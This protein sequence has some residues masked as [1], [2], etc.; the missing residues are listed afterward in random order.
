MLSLENKFVI[1]LTLMLC[2]SN[3]LAVS[4]HQTTNIMLPQQNAA[5]DVGQIQPCMD[6]R[7]VSLNVALKPF[8]KISIAI[9]GNFTVQEE[10]EFT[11]TLFVDNKYKNIFKHIQI[12]EN[13]GSLMIR[14]G[15]RLEKGQTPSFIGVITMPG[16]I[17]LNELSLWDHGILKCL[18]DIDTDF[19]NVILIDHSS[20]LLKGRANMHKICIGRTSVYNAKGIIAKETKGTVFSNSYAI[21]GVPGKMDDLKKDSESVITVLSSKKE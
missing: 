20:A 5:K 18:N 19:L 8:N 14:F 13:D 1:L 12:I 21:F 9:P 15:T 2:I 3:S 10:T 6:L 16:K 4:T 17:Q 7:K 11:I